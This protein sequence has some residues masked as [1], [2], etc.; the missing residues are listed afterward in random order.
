[1]SKSK[2]KPKEKLIK[3]LVS[4]KFQV[5]MLVE[6]VLAVALFIALFRGAGW[7]TVVGLAGAMVTAAGYYSHKKTQQNTTFARWEN[8]PPPARGGVGGV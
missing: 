6:V 3:N 8:L 5:V 1:M 4:T 7:E 2:L